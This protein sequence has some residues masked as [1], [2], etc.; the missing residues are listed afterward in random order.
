MFCC[1]TAIYRPKKMPVSKIVVAVFCVFWSNAFCVLTVFTLY[2]PWQVDIII[3]FKHIYIS[4]LLS[5]LSLLHVYQYQKEVLCGVL[6]YLLHLLQSRNPAIF[7]Q[8]NQL[9]YNHI[10]GRAYTEKYI[11]IYGIC[12]S[13]TGRYCTR[14]PEH[15]I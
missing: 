12:V 4:V 10:L 14:F 2:I 15:A 9:L 8:P 5:I 7:E 1:I 11:G 3:L 6:W 13:P